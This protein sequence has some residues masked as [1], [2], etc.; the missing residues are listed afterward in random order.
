MRQRAVDAFLGN[1][2]VESEQGSWVITIDFTSIDPAKAALIANRTAELFVQS[3]I[4]T[5]REDISHTSRWMREQIELVPSTRAL[6]PDLR[7]RRGRI[8]DHILSPIKRREMSLA[9]SDESVD[10]YLLYCCSYLSD[11]G[12][13]LA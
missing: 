10:G 6:R 5:K 9:R 3:Q 12:F 7:S 8:G 13:P 4:D 1:L 11:G 2:E